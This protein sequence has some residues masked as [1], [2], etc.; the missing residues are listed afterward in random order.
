MKDLEDS[1]PSDTLDV[2]EDNSEDLK[3]DFIHRIRPGNAL[4]RISGVSLFWRH[5][6]SD[7]STM[8]IF[9]PMRDLWECYFDCRKWWTR[10]L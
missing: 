8:E 4:F 1:E 3:A 9:V 2:T 10:G 7:P 6:E 5:M